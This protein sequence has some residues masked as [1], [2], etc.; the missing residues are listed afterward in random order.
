MV[1]VLLRRWVSER[2]RVGTETL[3]LPLCAAAL[4]L[5]ADVA[6]AQRKVDPQSYFRVA[7]VSGIGEDGPYFLSLPARA[8][9]G[10]GL[11]TTSEARTFTVSLSLNG[12]VHAVSNNASAATRDAEYIKLADSLERTAGVRVLVV[13]PTGKE[14]RARIW[15]RDGKEWRKN[16]ALPPEEQSAVSLQRWLEKVYG[17]AAWVKS[18]KGNTLTLRTS[19]SALARASGKQGLVVRGDVG[20]PLGDLQAA[21]PLLLVKCRGAGL[22][23]TCDTVLEGEGEVK[24]GAPVL[25]P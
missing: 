20:Q 16:E 21:G 12:K 18:L 1:V 6:H 14:T 19:P 24:P 9:N 17:Y 7:F 23:A 10:L 11:F 13:L 25:F 4:M 2:V 8:F 5:W 15:N 3:M 22:E